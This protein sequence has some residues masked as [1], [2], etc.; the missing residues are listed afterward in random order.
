MSVDYL[1]ERKHEVFHSAIEA[2]LQDGNLTD[3][4]RAIITQLHTSPGLDL[5]QACSIEAEV[6]RALAARRAEAFGARARVN[7]SP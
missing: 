4:E 5:P 3:P 7:A 1:I 2:A 6:S